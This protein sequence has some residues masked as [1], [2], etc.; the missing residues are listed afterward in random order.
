MPAR[1][2]ESIRQKIVELRDRG[3]T[4]ATIVAQT[5]VSRATV[6]RILQEVSR[7]EPASSKT[8]ILPEPVPEPQ[9]SPDA[10]AELERELRAAQLAIVRALRIYGDSY[11]R[12]CTALDE[13]RLPSEE[14]LLLAKEFYLRAAT[15]HQLL[16]SLA[17]VPAR[18][19]AA[20]DAHD[21]PPP[22][23][24]ILEPME[25]PPWNPENP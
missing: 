20:A 22:V 11:L 15:F 19:P 14:A 9:S 24:I 5:G 8:P 2:D 23:E 1:I 25:T 3:A 7:S 21:R 17:I 10:S 18:E 16:R 6:F 4:I 13:G 12:Y